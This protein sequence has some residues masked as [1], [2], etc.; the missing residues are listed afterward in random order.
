M[1]ESYIISFASGKETIVIEPYDVDVSTSLALYGKNC[2]N[3]WTDLNKNILL[4]LTNFSNP[5]PPND[6]IKGQ[7][8]FDNTTKELKYFDRDWYRLVPQMVDLSEYTHNN[9]DT[10]SGNLVLPDEPINTNSIVSRKYV[11]SK[12]F[13]YKHGESKTL[14]WIT[15]PNG[16]T[17]INAIITQNKQAVTFPFSMVDTNYSVI[18]TPNEPPGTSMSAMHYTVYNKTE[19]GFNV[20]IYDKVSSL[21]IVI[22]GFA[23]Q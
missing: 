16:Y 7:T 22:M 3:Y 1:D 15:L 6:P 20:N 17:I 23:P 12:V 5:T 4:L 8:W 14:N 11:E 13:K 10:L 21:A 19:T 9:N 2:L 18:V